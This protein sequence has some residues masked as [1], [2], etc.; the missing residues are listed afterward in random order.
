MYC[1]IMEYYK[2][3]DKGWTVTCFEGVPFVKPLTK[4]KHPQ[5]VLLPRPLTMFGHEELRWWQMPLY[6]YTQPVI[7][8]GSP[9]QPASGSSTAALHNLPVR[10]A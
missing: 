7:L 2:H 3:Y 4:R 10:C 8:S 6:V 9:M 5:N 1:C